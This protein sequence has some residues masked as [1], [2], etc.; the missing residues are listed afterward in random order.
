MP[1]D[2]DLIV[3]GSGPAGHHAAVEAAKS[4]RRAAIVDRGADLGGVCLHTGTIPSKTLR[5][6]VLFLSGFR[7]RSFY[8]RGYRVK[9]RIQIEDLMFRV[10]EVIK[11][12]YAVIQDQLQRQ[13]VDVLEG[14]ARFT[15]DPHTVEV[16]AAGDPP[17]RY[18]ADFVLIACGT[19]PARRD[20]VPFDAEQ[21][22]DSDE[23]IR[24]TKGELPKSLIV[25]GGG[26]IGLEYA[27]MMAAMGSA[28]TVVEA[29]DSLL[30][31]VDQEI[32]QTLMYHLRRNG[33][34]FRLGEK[35]TS[36]TAPP[37]SPVTATLE[38][39]KALTAAALLYAVGRQPNTDRLNLDAI[40]L[41][42]SDRGQLTVNAQFQT[43][44]PHIYAAGDVVG[45]PSL[46]STSMEQ[47]RLAACHM[48]ARAGPICCL[49]ASTP[50]PKSRW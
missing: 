13:G 19:R 7:Q 49:T 47:G 42:T 11:R 1:A 44:V 23:F 36:V 2:Y 3:I 29:R 18:T 14:H 20:D 25:V 22:Y 41:K 26:V 17:R 15:A 5:E 8:G 35:V 43:A 32:T 34:T 12:Q 39:G 48:F 6:A 21:V 50:S 4:G 46:A 31:Y 16:E 38:S 27:S 37:N 10:G 28:V 33:V 40:G 24:V 9:A 45:F 30:A